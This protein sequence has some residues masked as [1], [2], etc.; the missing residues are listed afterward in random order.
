MTK[1]KVSVMEAELYTIETDDM[2][3]W[4]KADPELFDFTDYEVDTTYFI[5]R[6][7]ND[8]LCAYIA[9]KLG[10]DWQDRYGIDYIDDI[11]IDHE[12]LID[13]AHEAIYDVLDNNI[14]RFFL[15]EVKRVKE[16]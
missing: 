13:I 2:G 7:D 11:S 3:T 4:I 1:D 5:S 15:D 14:T 6:E 8:K 10:Y 12:D 16:D 9:K